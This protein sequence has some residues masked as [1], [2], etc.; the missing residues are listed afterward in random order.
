MGNT[1]YFD[2]EIWLMKF[3]QSYM[4]E[5]AI[6]LCICITYLGESAVLFVLMAFIYL[7]YDKDI[8]RKLALSVCMSLVVNP[9][10][11]NVFVRRR[12]YF[13]NEDILCLKKV[14]ESH[15][16]YD[17]SS[18]G[19]SFPSGHSMSATC[20]YGS[21]PLYFKKRLFLIIA[22][23]VPF[24]VGFSRVALGV[25]YPTDVLVG[26]LLGGLVIAFSRYLDR[27]VTSKT[28]L[29]GVICGVSLLGLLF[30]TT[31]DFYKG[32]GT[33]IGFCVSDLIEQKYV[34]FRITREKGRSLIRIIVAVI[35]AL[36]FKEGAKMLLSFTRSDLI[37][38]F[39]SYFL[40]ISVT[41][42]LVPMFYGKIYKYKD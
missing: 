9:L 42:G 29:Y 1:F 23:S 31:N 11:K 15:D 33:L 20:F 36:A 39:V 28:L 25:H 10:V 7:C 3:I 6:A 32:L 19:Y 12:P 24:I 13:D 8:G 27:K 16:L 4:N 41:F 18:Q 26:F 40:S 37:K 5:L 14:E 34:N 2:F 35:S 22:I 21:L 17:I 30:C 38:Y